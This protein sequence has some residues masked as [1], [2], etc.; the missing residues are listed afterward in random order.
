MIHEAKNPRLVVT[1]LKKTPKNLVLKHVQIY[2]LQQRSHVPKFGNWDG[3][4]V[5]YTAYFENARKEKTNGIRINPNDPEQNPEAFNI[6]NGGNFDRERNNDQHKQ[7]DG[8]SRRTFSSGSSS[9]GGSS[10]NLMLKPK[11]QSKKSGSS[12]P[13]NGDDDFV[14]MLLH[15]LN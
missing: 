4:N 1:L 13:N 6:I 11:H 10:T 12:N 7:K 3:D 15:M 9:N 2:I 8:G 14:S 5:P